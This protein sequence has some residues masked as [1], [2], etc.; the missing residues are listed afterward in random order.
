MM[1]RLLLITLTL[2]LCSGTISAQFTTVTYDTDKQWFNEGQALP[3]EKAMVFKGL[4]AEGTERVE[5]QILSAKEN[6]LYTAVGQRQANGEFTVPVNYM[7]RA[8]ERYDFNISF[9]R[10]ISGSEKDNLKQ[11][12]LSTLNTYVEVNLSGDKS[13]KLLKKPAKVVRDMNDIVMNILSPYRSGVVD[14][15]PSFSEVIRLKLE[16]LDRANLSEG[17]DK[18]DTTATLKSAQAAAKANL[19]RGLEAQLQNEVNQMLN[20]DMMV[21]HSTQ[22]ID[23]YQTA[24]KENGLSINVG[25]GGVY[26]SGDLNDLTYGASPYVGLA[27]P[28]GNSVLG[29]KFLS[30]SS[31]TIGVFLDTFEDADGK[32]VSG[33]LIEQPIYLGLDYKLFKFLRINA[34][35]AFLEEGNNGA[36]TDVMI[37]PFVGL[38]A[39][40]D[41]A[42]G[43]GK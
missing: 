29:S 23:D 33:V 3:A 5:I 1:N 30:N 25:Y 9:F 10:A 11:S 26:L 39:R 22:K 21:V 31:V 19:I 36:G 37:R 2:L 32:E 43:L 38:S 4:L 7:L 28:L 40:I 12:I 13:I 6:L 16:Q 35:A 18:K 34:G 41:L 42:I 27:F 14:W 20:V 15:Q 24:S 8:S 17:F